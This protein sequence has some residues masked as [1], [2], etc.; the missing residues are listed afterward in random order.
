[1]LVN[2]LKQL[3]KT[4]VV[5]IGITTSS[6]FIA[7]KIESNLVEYLKQKNQYVNENSKTPR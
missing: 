1:M 3:V 5:G 7:C 4:G 2:V 6:A